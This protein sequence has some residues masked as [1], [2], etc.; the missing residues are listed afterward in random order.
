MFA[1]ADLALQHV[2][3]RSD[4]LENY[5]LNLIWRDSKV[6]TYIFILSFFLSFIFFIVLIYFLRIRQYMIV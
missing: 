2:N 4:L 3:N 5:N 6:S 1:G